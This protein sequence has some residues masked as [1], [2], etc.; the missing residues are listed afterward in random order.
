M[1]KKN[2]KIKCFTFFLTEFI[3]YFVSDVYGLTL[4]TDLLIIVRKV[5]EVNVFSCFLQ[6][7]FKYPDL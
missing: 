3:K 1:I 5:T 4:T 2:K 7:G 6:A